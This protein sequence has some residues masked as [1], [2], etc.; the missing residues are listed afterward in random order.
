MKPSQCAFEAAELI[1]RGGWTQ[2]AS[3][4]D[5]NNDKVSPL[6]EFA[7]S[8]CAMG[9]LRRVAGGE[10][11][12]TPDKIAAILDLPLTPILTLHPLATFNDDRARTKEEVINILREAGNKLKERGE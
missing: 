4:R 5:I 2:S 3:A 1:E 8:W 10:Y 11:P 6:S 12:E 9:A 7:C